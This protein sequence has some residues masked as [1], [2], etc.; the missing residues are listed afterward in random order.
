MKKN[1]QEKEEQRENSRFRAFRKDK[2]FIYYQKKN[3]FSLH[4]KA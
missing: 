2:N 4:K 1:Q 3:H